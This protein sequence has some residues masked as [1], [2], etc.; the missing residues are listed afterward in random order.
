MIQDGRPHHTWML[1]QTLRDAQMAILLETL[2]HFDGHRGVTAKVL[3]ISVRTLTNWIQELK[4][5][6]IDPPGSK[7][8][9]FYPRRDKP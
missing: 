3:G 5:A 4:R 9:K 8:G 7:Y 1:G 2:K 6:G